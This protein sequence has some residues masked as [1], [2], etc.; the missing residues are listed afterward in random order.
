MSLRDGADHEIFSVES[1]GSGLIRHTDNES[2]EFSPRWSPDGHRLAF[3]RQSY[4]WIA[5]GSGETQ[6]PSC[7]YERE[8]AWAPEGDRLAFVRQYGKAIGL[9][10]VDLQG[11][12]AVL[13]EGFWYYEALDWSPTGEWI[14]FDRFW[15]DTGQQARADIWL[16]RPDGTDKHRIT[17]EGEGARHPSWS[18]DGTHLAFADDDESGDL[19]IYTLRLSDG[20]VVRVSDSP[21][22]DYDPVWSPD[23]SR[24]AFVSERSGNA[25]VYAMNLDGSELVRLTDDP[26][27]DT[28]PD[29]GPVPSSSPPSAVSPSPRSCEIDVE[30]SIE[31]ELKRHLR[32]RGSLQEEPFSQGRCNYNLLIQR[33]TRSGRWENVGSPSTFPEFRLRLEDRPGR[34]RALLKAG[35]GFPMYYDRYEYN[36]ERAVSEVVQHRHR[37]S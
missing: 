32:L 17:P 1:D 37:N 14:A 8:A 11:E 26:A 23:G 20:H 25:D 36:C 21:G 28:D 34:Y 4:I 2:F 16:I 12:S 18:P 15:W 27:A 22:P 6:L 29:W 3:T 13:D 35:H 5:D 10:V 24:L 31:I 9:G 33:R 7:Y 30:R 19:D